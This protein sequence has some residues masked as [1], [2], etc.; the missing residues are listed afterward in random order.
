MFG[1]F[2]IPMTG[3]WG[4]LMLG[5]AVGIGTLSIAALGIG[6][7]SWLYDVNVLST[8]RPPAV[9]LDVRRKRAPVQYTSPTA[10]IKIPTFPEARKPVV[11]GRVV[12]ELGRPEMAVP[13]PIKPAKPAKPKKEQVPLLAVAAVSSVISWLTTGFLHRQKQRNL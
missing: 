1:W 8:G 4:T 10:E 7:F 12:S 11:L 5:L 13:S 6:V 9:S 3:I 2:S